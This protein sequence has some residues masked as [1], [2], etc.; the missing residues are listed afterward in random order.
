MKIDRVKASGSNNGC[1]LCG[2]QT[3]LCLLLLV[4]A[5]L[6]RMNRNGG[7]FSSSLHFILFFHCSVNVLLTASFQ[8]LTF[9]R[10]SL[11]EIVF[12]VWCYSGIQICWSS[13][14]C[15][16]ACGICVTPKE[17]THNFT[18]KKRARAALQQ[19]PVRVY[20]VY[21]R[22]SSYELLTYSTCSHNY[23]WTI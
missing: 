12:P 8:G 13:L 4:L 9:S 15:L 14:E 21:S 2:N 22:L 16:L 3:N 11:Q 19:V 5:C 6:Y 23:T 20:F 18:F 1:S 17:H 7:W 10:N